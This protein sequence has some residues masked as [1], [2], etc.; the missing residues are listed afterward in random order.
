[1][2]H[3]HAPS[4]H[5]TKAKDKSGVNRPVKQER[6][7]SHKMTDKYSRPTQKQKT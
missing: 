2:K 4:G 5:A 7:P 6:I 1:M 3:K